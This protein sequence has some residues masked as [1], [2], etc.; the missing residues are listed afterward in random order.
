MKK[1]LT[2]LLIFVLLAMQFACYSNDSLDTPAVVAPPVVTDDFIRAVDISFL[3]QI[4]SA[5]VVLYND[6]KAED[7]LATLK[8][9]RC[10][11]VRIRLW[12]NPVDRHF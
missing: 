10:N 4:E 1:N 2:L 11:T 3:P 8:N 12:K 6:A 7:M 5:G 9:A